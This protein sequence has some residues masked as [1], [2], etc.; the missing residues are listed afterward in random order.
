MELKDDYNSK[1]RKNLNKKAV[2]RKNDEALFILICVVYLLSILLSVHVKNIPGP[3]VNPQSYT[4]QII[5]ATKSNTCFVNDRGIPN[6]DFGDTAVDQV[7][8]TW[9]QHGVLVFGENYHSKVLF[10][11]GNL[12]FTN[13]HNLDQSGNDEYDTVASELFV[14]HLIIKNSPSTQAS[15]YLRNQYF[16]NQSNY[17]N[18]VITASNIIASL[19][20]DFVPMVNGNGE[21]KNTNNTDNIVSIHSA[22]YSDDCSKHNDDGRIESFD[23]IANDRRTSNYKD[24]L[25][26]SELEND[27]ID[28]NFITSDDDDGDDDD[29]NDAENMSGGDNDDD[30]NREDSVSTNDNTNSIT[31]PAD[32]TPHWMLLVVM[33]DD[34][35]NYDHDCYHDF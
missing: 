17:P 33:A 28:D 34:D 20:I 10:N 35:N 14:P 19:G 1:L 9:T 18:T 27:N 23:T 8:A 16:V 3:K 11:D 12:T 13:Y 24:V 21:D 4:L 7:L 15:M 30:S 29:D 26:A 22:D 5:L 2:F 25:V 32:T 31:N 6:I